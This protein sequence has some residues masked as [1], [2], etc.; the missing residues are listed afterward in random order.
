MSKQQDKL[1]EDD[2]SEEYLG[3]V[4]DNTDSEFMGRCK[5]K[6]FG[7]FDTLTTDE[8]P[9]CFPVY[10]N[11][12]GGDNGAGRISIP[13]VGTIVRVKFN[14]GNLYAPEYY[15]IQ[16]LAS[17]LQDTLKGDYQN[18]HS[19][20]W[21]N[22]EQLKL[23]YAKNTGLLFHLKDSIIN[24]KPDSSISIEHKDS[25][26]SIELK[27]PNITITSDAKI[28][29]VAN[30]QINQN[31]NEINVTGTKTNLGANP[32]FSNINGE[33]LFQFLLALSQAVDAKWPLSPGV[34]AS[35]ATTAMQAS[36]SKTV[37]TTP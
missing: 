31:S 33:P 14:N 28:D 27:G 8:M 11:Q 35:L 12:F 30:N 17:S 5:V 34:M 32:I 4:V 23:Y 37:K 15:A 9:W 21:D 36:I 1:F 25:R 7:K 6:V 2:L 18:F 10:D 29:I 13:K 3:E 20:G 16:N 24:I 26:S 19:F 22:D